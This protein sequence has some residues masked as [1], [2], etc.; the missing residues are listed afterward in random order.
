MKKGVYQSVMASLVSFLAWAIV[1]LWFATCRFRVHGDPAWRQRLAAAEPAI[2]TFWHYGLLPLMYL[3]RNQRGT[4]MISTSRD[5]EYIHR[6][7]TRLGYE[8]VRGSRNRRGVAAL[9]G[10]LAALKKGRNLGLV[11]DGS[12]GPA[13]IAQPGA[14]LLASRTG[15]PILP[16][17][18]AASR[19]KRFGSWDG[20]ILPLPFSRIDCYFGE[21][22]EL[23]QGL[24]SEGLEAG[25]LLL[26][27]RLDALYR[28][29]WSAL[30]K[31]EH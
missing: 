20:T 5:A 18:C 13:R 10:L 1:R 15:A 3:L 14:V 19:Y 22:I 11:A 7:A 12:Q 4:V 24:D 23:E 9:K 17:V 8:S 31:E 25:R 26:E 30:G 6:I 27:Q 28:Q 21:A 29:A 2:C 16:V